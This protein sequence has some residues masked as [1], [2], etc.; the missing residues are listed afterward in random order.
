M[1]ERSLPSSPLTGAE[2]A[3]LPAPYLVGQTCRFAPIKKPPYLPM[4]PS[5]NRHEPNPFP[6]TQP[7]TAFLIS[8]PCPSIGGLKMVGSSVTLV[9]GD[10]R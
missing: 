2:R 3:T 1:K 5:K 8:Y 9:S 4:L 6:E 10:L 7:R